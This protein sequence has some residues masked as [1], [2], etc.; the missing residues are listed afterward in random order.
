VCVQVVVECWCSAP[1]PAAPSLA[2]AYHTGTQ[3]VAAALRLPVVLSKFLAPVAVTADSFFA[4]WKQYLNPPNRIQEIV[5][6]AASSA[7]ALLLAVP[8]CADASWL[9]PT[10]RPP[11]PLPPPLLGPVAGCVAADP[12]WGGLCRSAT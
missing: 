4:R 1:F 8:G 6:A 10:L 11:P 2:V 5:S 9:W 12:S 7:S 3:P